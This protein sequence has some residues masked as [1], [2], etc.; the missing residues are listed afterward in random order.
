MGVEESRRR[1]IISVFLLFLLTV[2][3]L[4]AERTAFI[5]YWLLNAKQVANHVWPGCS[6]NRFW[7]GT[8]IN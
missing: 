8:F 4:P 3:L 2:E 1:E 5:L 7:L 6:C